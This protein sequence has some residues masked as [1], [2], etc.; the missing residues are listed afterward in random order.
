M[1]AVI[2][3]GR[4]EWSLS[5]L[6]QQS[7]DV[8]FCADRLSLIGEKGAI[9]TRTDGGKMAGLTGDIPPDGRRKRSAYLEENLFPSGGHG[10]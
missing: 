10:E 2:F 8:I 4:I 3:P 7:Q 5:S 1:S 6:H 9:G